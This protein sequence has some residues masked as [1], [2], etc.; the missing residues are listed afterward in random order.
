MST[1][2]NVKC[3]DCKRKL[4]SHD[5]LTYIGGR[6][7]CWV[8]TDAYIGDAYPTV[9]AAEYPGHAF[10]LPSTGNAALD[11]LRRHVTGRVLAGEAEAI[12]EQPAPHVTT[13]DD[14]ARPMVTLAVI[15]GGGPNPG[16]KF[17][18]TYTLNTGKTT[19]TTKTRTGAFIVLR[20]MVGMRRGNGRTVAGYTTDQLGDFMLDAEHGHTLIIPRNDLAPYGPHLCPG[21]CG[22]VLMAPTAP[23]E[24]GDD[25]WYC[26]GCGQRWTLDLTARTL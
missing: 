16:C 11:T 15:G 23:G 8:C 6:W 19:T 10:A 25:T 26:P 13:V 12:V 17:S 22:T 2:T 9:T 3:G 24:A 7:R 4:D 5:T 1:P 20:K 21:G 14:I 18:L